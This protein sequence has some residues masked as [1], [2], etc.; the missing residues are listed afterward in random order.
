M[1]DAAARRRATRLASTVLLGVVAVV[2]V[3]ILAGNGGVFSYTLDDPYIHLELARAL[4]R[5]EHGLNPGE[6]A[7]PSSSLLWPL[8]LVPAWALPGTVL[9]PLVLATLAALAA[10]PAG[11]RVVARS[12][13]A[14]PPWALGALTVAFTLLAN[15]PALALT[16]MEHAAHVAAVAWAAAGLVAVDDEDRVPWWLVPALVVGP[17]LRFEGLGLALVAGAWLAWRGHRT[18][19]LVAALVPSA[20]VA[21]YLVWLHGRTGLWLPFSI[22]SKKA[23]FPSAWREAWMPAVALP[24]GL[25]L[26]TL[27]YAVRRSSREAELPLLAVAVAVGHLAFGQ[28]G[29]FSRY[30][31]YVATFVSLVAAWS[32]RDVLRSRLRAGGEAARILGWTLAL[33]L[34]VPLQATWLSL[35][36]GHHIWRLQGQL[37]RLADEVAEGPVAVNDVGWVSYGT[38]RY[39]VDVAG[40][41]SEEVVKHIAA[42]DPPAGWMGDLVRARG[43]RLVM[44]YHHWFPVVPAS[45]VPLGW[46]EA[47]RSSFSRPDR[48]VRLYA[49][50]ASDAAALTERL[51]AFRGT[52]PEGAVIVLEGEPIELP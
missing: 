15:L 28:I 24:T 3:G 5:G 41:S 13:G 8:L 29:L 14:A 30:V 17:M 32:L 26:A 20:V 2:L 33:F 34:V 16:G 31:A 27:A 42:G 21:A 19:G 10:I 23:M 45:W 25:A 50:D 36:A 1:A 51:R 40:L 46:L 12:V 52:L 18:A 22:L 35:G 11:A 37:R 4:A 39:V 7:A 43:A 9:V 48:M 47:E 38:D 6:F 44:V 49:S